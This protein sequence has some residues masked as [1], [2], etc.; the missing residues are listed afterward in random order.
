MKLNKPEI[1]LNLQLADQKKALTK[2]SFQIESYSAKDHYCVD[3]FPKE[4]ATCII[5]L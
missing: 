1:T 3:G 2:E 5:I 4:K